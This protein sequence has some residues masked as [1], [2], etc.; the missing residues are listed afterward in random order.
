MVLLPFLVLALVCANI[1]LMVFARTAAREGELVVRSALGASRGR[2]V[3]QLFVEALVL[4]SAGAVVGLLAG[5]FLVR[6]VMEL[7]DAETWGSVPYWFHRGLSLPTSL[8]VYHLLGPGEV[9]PVAMLVHA[10]GPPL[11]LAPRLRTLAGAVDSSLRLRNVMR[12]DEAVAAEMRPVALGVLAGGVILLGLGFVISEFRLVSQIAASGRVAEIV[13][14]AAGYL[15]VMLGVCLI[16]CVVPTRRALT[17]E[18][19]EALRA[20]G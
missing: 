1:V 20:D 15:V 19:T 13:M 9:Y 6:H 17:I 8:Y 11:A 4:A 2:V 5:D 14:G 3:M 18:P 12:L 16:S 7:I 10:A